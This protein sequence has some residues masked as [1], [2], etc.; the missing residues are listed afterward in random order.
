MP[1]WL[2]KLK[3]GVS[4]RTH[5]ICASLLWTAVGAALLYRGASYLRDEKAVGVAVLGII[6][7]SLKSRFILDKT[8]IR[9]VERIKRFGDNTCIGAVYSWKTWLLVIFMMLMGLFLRMSSISPALAG[10]LCTAI[11]WSLLYSSRHGWREL[12]NFHI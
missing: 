5:L 3:P 9:G 7:G 2:A 8:A 6:L 1:S 11:G 10:L 4:P 12:T